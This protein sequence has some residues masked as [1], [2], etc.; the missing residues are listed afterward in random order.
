MCKS[1]RIIGVIVAVAIAFI[2][3]TQLVTA[4]WALIT[5]IAFNP[6]RV[7]QDGMFLGIGNQYGPGSPGWVTITV[8]LS[9]TDEVVGTQA[10]YLPPHLVLE[11]QSVISSG[12]FYYYYDR[13]LPV[14][15]TIK[16]GPPS[17][18]TPAHFIIEN[19]AVAEPSLPGHLFFFSADV[20]RRIPPSP[21][22]NVVTSTLFVPAHTIISDINVALYISH[23][24]DSDLVATLA[25]PAGISITLFN[26]VGGNDDGFG[27]DDR[28]LPPL[29]YM[30]NFVL[31]DQ[32]L[33]DVTSGMAPFTSTAY[34]P[35]GPGQLSDFNGEDAAGLWTLTITD[36]YPPLDN[37]SLE[38]WALEITSYKTYLPTIMKQ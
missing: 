38:Y 27:T 34:R 15:S 12:Y 21:S 16:V 32:S 2:L 3:T 4:R 1:F 24:W 31:D 19:C 35:Q 8:K 29:G 6:V 20:P 36:L 26:G 9:P 23:T 10:F 17:A 37:G 30:P 11:K 5:N 33:Y 18:A 25:S 13:F 7:C 22:L 28:L 14:S